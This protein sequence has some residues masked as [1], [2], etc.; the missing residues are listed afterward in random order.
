MSY[1]SRSKVKYCDRYT[2]QR[3]ICQIIAPLYMSKVIY[4][5]LYLGQRS[6][7]QIKMTSI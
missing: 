5:D 3:S 1:M 4:N 2:G 7:G 6:T